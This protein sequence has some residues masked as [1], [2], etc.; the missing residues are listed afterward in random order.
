MASLPN[1]GNVKY[2]GHALMYGINNDFLGFTEYRD[3]NNKVN[4]P[5][6]FAREQIGGGTAQMGLGNFVQ[7][8][9]NFANKKVEGDVLQ[10]LAERHA[11][12][13]QPERCDCQ[14]P[15]SP[16][17][18]RQSWVIPSLVRQTAFMPRAMTKPISAHPSLVDSAGNGWRI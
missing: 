1:E 11:G 5:N 15:E 2:E 12:K 7:A 13:R 17:Q 14:R 10:R 18:R 9:V 6:A 4:L 8:D 3:P 16:F